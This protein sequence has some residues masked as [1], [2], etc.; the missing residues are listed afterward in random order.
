MQFQIPAERGEKVCLNG[1]QKKKAP[2]RKE[3][4]LK[5]LGEFRDTV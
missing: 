1:F 4:V 3:K 5:G 2:V